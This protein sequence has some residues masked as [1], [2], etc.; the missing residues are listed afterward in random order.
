MQSP[1]IYEHGATQFEV[2]ADGR[3]YALHRLHNRFYDGPRLI[4]GSKTKQGYL[5]ILVG[6]RNGKRMM[7][8]RLVA[9]LYI[10]NPSNKPTINHKDGNKTNNAVSNLEWAT[11]SENH[12]HA[13]RNLGR[14]PG[15]GRTRNV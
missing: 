10:P 13:F 9:L 1:R 8:H 3:I 4:L 12:L 7:Q 11:H 15:R 6:G 2:H 5:S 14:R